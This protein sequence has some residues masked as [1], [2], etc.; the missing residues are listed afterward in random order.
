MKTQAEAMAEQLRRAVETKC[1]LVLAQNEMERRH[2]QGQIAKDG[3][4]KDL[5]VYIQEILESQA[6]A[7]L[8]FMN[9]IS[10]LAKKL[11]VTEAKHRKEIDEKDFEISQLESKVE[12]MRISLVQ[13]SPSHKPYQ[14]RY[15]DG[16]TSSNL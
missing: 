8:N 9:E 4:L 6:H 1:D 7:E 14:N 11:E 5:R 3:E 12:S 2:E 13:G 16:P 15:S 10:S